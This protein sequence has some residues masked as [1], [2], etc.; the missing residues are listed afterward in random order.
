M[1]SPRHRPPGET[2]PKTGG[3]HDLFQRPDDN[4]ATVADR[5]KVYDE[6]TSPLAKFYDDRGLLRRIDAEGELDVV[7]ARLEAVL[8]GGRQ[9]AGRPE[10]AQ[11]SARK[12][13]KK[14]AKKAATKAATK[15]PRQGRE[16]SRQETPAATKPRHGSREIGGTRK[17]AKT[18]R[19][20]GS[21]GAGTQTAARRVVTASGSGNGTTRQPAEALGARASAGRR[22]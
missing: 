1:C 3:E 21:Q 10:R 7:T 2:C 22:R 20:R 13:L 14:P 17:R 5:L 18:S 11:E 19:A 15:A 12:A 16:E 4:E 9:A 6:K 8:A